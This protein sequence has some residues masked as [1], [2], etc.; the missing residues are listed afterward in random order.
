MESFSPM[1]RQ[2]P[3]TRKT[4]PRL[5]DVF[6]ERPS[7]CSMCIDER[8]VE[9]QRPRPKLADVFGGQETSSVPHRST[10]DT[11]YT[12]RKG[13]P[14]LVNAQEASLVPY[15]S[16]AVMPYMTKYTTRSRLPPLVNTQDTSFAPFMSMTVMPHMMKFSPAS[17]KAREIVHL[18]HKTEKQ[19]SPFGTPRFGEEE[20]SPRSDRRPCAAEPGLARGESYVSS[21]VH[22]AGPWSHARRVGQNPSRLKSQDAETSASAGQFSPWSQSRLLVRAATASTRASS[23]DLGARASEVHRLDHIH[24]QPAMDA[25]QATPPSL[26]S[27][28]SSSSLARRRGLKLSNV[29]TRPLPTSRS[30]AVRRA[31]ELDRING[32]VP[33]WVS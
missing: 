15:M 24:G 14:P 31:P 2:L 16:A 8:V 20:S 19:D 17:A 22:G 9:G 12:T 26:A 32:V 18:L 25:G 10:A 21:S 28:S 29:I 3:S 11:M 27:S 1:G 7:G 33:G 23:S 6:G 4:R 5:R 30:P 13:S